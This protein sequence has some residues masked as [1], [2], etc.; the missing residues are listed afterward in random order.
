MTTNETLLKRRTNAVPRGVRNAFPV[1]PQRAVNAEIWDVEGKRYIDFASGIAVLNVGHSHPRVRAAVAQQ[2]ESYQHLGFQVTPYEPYIELAERLNKLAPG[3]GKKKTIFLSTG[4]EAVENAV[5]IART[6]TGRPG[7]IT[8]TGGFHGRTLLT[9]AMTGKVIP[10]KVGFGPLPGEVFHLPFPSAYHGITEKDS[11]HSLE[12]LFKSDL[13]PARVAAIVIE[14]VQGEGGFN[15]APFGFLRRLRA[16]CDDHG[17]VLVADEIQ[18]GFGRTGK[19]FGIEHSG[20][21]PDMMTVAK[22]LAGGMPL[23]GV[24]GKAEIM[25]APAPG[26]LGGTYGGNPVACA[27]ALA[28][29]DIIKDEKLLE[30]SA[31]IGR[32]LSRR[33]KAMAKKPAGKCIGDIRG[34]GAMTAIE[35]VKDRKSRRPAPELANAVTQR[36]LQNGLM[37]L[38]CGVYGNVLR[39]LAPLTISDNTLNEGLDILEKTLQQAAKKL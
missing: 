12:N 6:H 36:A 29:L 14:P 37:L 16:L 39:I 38:G 34:L 32:L 20:V 4:A 24:I 30:R 23:S 15:V 18:S 7:V 5:K 2:M 11:F 10:Y 33:F 8:F 1:F 26:G 13:E 17:I 21:V 19:F 9:L 31:A 25:D 28:V 35:L 22:S 3:R 27:A